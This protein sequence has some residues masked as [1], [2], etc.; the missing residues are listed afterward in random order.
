MEQM[1]GMSADFHADADDELI[2]ELLVDWQEAIDRREAGSLDEICDRR[3][4]LIPRVRARI[5]SLAEIDHLI[6]RL[7]FHDEVQLPPVDRDG[8]EAARVPEI[9]GYK[10]LAELGRGGM[11]IVFKALQE[12]LNRVVAIKVIRGGRW[13]SHRE[14]ERF[15]SEAEVL[16]KIQHHGVVQIY[17]IL[18]QDGLLCL[19]LEYVSGSS[20]SESMRLHPTSPVE[21]A[22]IVY[23]VAEVIS[24]VHAKGVLHRDIKPANIL[25]DA[26]GR[27]KITDF[28]IAKALV[29]SSKQTMSGEVLG[30]PSYMAPEL[31]LEKRNLIT[32]RTDVY[33]IGATLYE[34][35]TRRAPFGGTSV[36]ETFHQ[37]TNDQPL[38]PHLFA[39]RIPQDLATICL[40]CLEKDPDRR[41]HSANLLRDDLDRFLH[42]RPILARPVSTFER[43]QRWC[44]RNPERAFFRF[45]SILAILIIVVG[46]SWFTARLNVTQKEMS[47]KQEALDS[48]QFHARLNRLRAQSFVRPQGWLDAGLAEV[49]SISKFAKTAEKRQ[50]LR[51]EAIHL[52]TQ[53]DVRHRKTLLTGA[54]ICRVAHHPTRPILALA[55]N[56]SV[57]DQ[58]VVI[59]LLDTSTGDPIRSVSFPVRDQEQFPNDAEG[60]RSLLFSPSGQDLFVGTR[61]GRVY[62]FNADDWTCRRTWNA[63]DDRVMGF[64]MDDATGTIYTCSRSG[65]VKSWNLGAE[66]ESPPG[67][68][69]TKLNGELFGLQY[70]NHCLIIC[71]GLVYRHDLR[72][73]EETMVLEGPARE[74]SALSLCPGASTAL[75]GCGRRLFHVKPELNHH[76][77]YVFRELTD[78][79]SPMPHADTV[80]SLAVSP[81]GRFGVSCGGNAL[82]VWDFASGRPIRSISLVDGAGKAV[83]FLPDAATFVVAG[84]GQVELYEI[85][86]NRNW[87]TF[88]VGE[89]PAT[90]ATVSP[91]GNALFHAGHK[92]EATH[93]TELHRIDLKSNLRHGAVF[94]PSYSIE[95]VLILGNTIQCLNRSRAE[96]YFL[97][98]LDAHD[99]TLKSRTL[100]GNDV[101]HLTL[102]PDGRALYYS[103][104]DM[105]SPALGRRPSAVFRGALPVSDVTMC[106]SNVASA[107]RLRKSQILAI[108]VGNELFATA[109]RDGQLRIHSV[110]D[111]TVVATQEL[112]ADITCLGIAADSYLFCGNESGA[113]QLRRFRDGELLEEKFEHHAKI[114]CLEV[115]NGGRTVVSG[116]SDGYL[117]FWHFSESLAK[118]MPGDRLGPLSGSIRRVSASSDGKIIAIVVQ[119]EHATRVLDLGELERQVTRL[120]L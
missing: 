54:D 30:T 55:E 87:K 113:V 93:S 68:L 8:S 80:E 36:A 56:V 118:L 74:G 81:D 89:T 92:T 73:H 111:G 45:F 6:E 75:I 25:I 9:P 112:D 4:D 39:A 53:H 40:K 84:E 50:E 24:A 35:M 7:R 66:S 82:K 86:T 18:E 64:T 19:I 83:Q 72:S 27:I 107:Q 16:A 31:V 2:A 33:A 10:I 108:A 41:Y 23:D 77:S 15:R 13:V 78:P 63:H 49:S 28:G 60:C 62:Q 17:D 67:V 117:H 29:T 21:A 48:E 109:S 115:T 110:K 100:L 104:D 44:R 20:L 70:F 119:G 120:G 65:E 59:R 52:S 46:A 61:R 103:A 3:P 71:G 76:T 22:A 98:E 38:P 79:K 43:C 106:W 91:D 11:G 58:N 114:T 96:E 94:S 5:E 26:D 37:I 47:D 95:D 97:E 69:V 90:T 12:R 51:N 34:L 14:I 32:E 101:Q 105:Q 85:S 42:G 102:E 88:T 99:L 116:C 1:D 57:D